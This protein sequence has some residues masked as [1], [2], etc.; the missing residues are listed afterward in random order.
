MRLKGK[1]ALV[2]GGARG[3]GSAIAE[4][5]AEEGALVVVSDISGD[6]ARLFASRLPN[7]A[8]GIEMDVSSRPSITKAI[9]FVDALLDGIDILVNNA[10]LFEMQPLLEVT[11][12]SYDKL[13]GVNTRG[14][15][16]TLQAVAQ[17][18]VH[19]S[20]RGVVLNLASQAGRRGE[21]A[22]SVYAASKAAV[23][24][25]T[26]SA[27]LALIGQG[28]RVNAIAPGVVDTP[29]WAQV[30]RLYAHLENVPL[31]DK[32]QR[33]AAA[34]PY[35]RL[36]RAK[37]IANAALFLASDEAEYVVGQTLNVDGGNVL[38]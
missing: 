31:G 32:T 17:T 23:I 27:A 2:T 15:F 10:G 21:A 12:T 20:K 35:G 34:I 28:I 19:R 36:A 25:I 1:I 4:R 7:G 3:I 33:V 11:E 13:F 9:E 30:D 38:S 37:E 16:F 22:S 18:M 5:F 6:E 29:M 26:Q 24:S 8:L 14:L